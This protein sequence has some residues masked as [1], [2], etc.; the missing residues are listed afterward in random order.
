MTNRVST[1][2]RSLASDIFANI[3]PRRVIEL[4]LQTF[5]FLKQLDSCENYKI[6]T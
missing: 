6:N 3:A 1:V 4:L 2:S 5:H